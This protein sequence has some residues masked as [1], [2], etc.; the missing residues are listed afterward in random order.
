MQS[1]VVV[2][3]N[4]CGGAAAIM[5][6]QHCCVANVGQSAAEL[7][8]RARNCA[9]WCCVR[10]TGARETQTR[11]RVAQLRR[12]MIASLCEPRMNPLRPEAPKTAKKPVPRKGAQI[13]LAAV[14]H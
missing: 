2:C 14:T 7:A 1:E 6:P 13:E 3:V 12:A 5:R 10:Y 4:C 9:V 11:L 8:K